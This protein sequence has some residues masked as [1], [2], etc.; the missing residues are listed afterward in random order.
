MKDESV[1][2]KNQIHINEFVRK[3][4]ENISEPNSIKESEEFI[5]LNSSILDF[6]NKYLPLNSGLIDILKKIQNISLSI[7]SV[8]NLIN[9]YTQFLNNIHTDIEKTFWGNINKQVKSNSLPNYLSMGDVNKEKESLGD[10]SEEINMDDNKLLEKYMD[11][12]NRNMQDMEKRLAEDRRD[13]E[14]RTEEQRRLSE[15]RMEKN[16]SE[17]MDAIKYQNEKIDKLEDKIDNNA[18]ELRNI[19]VTTIWSMI[20]IVAAIA[21]LVLTVILTIK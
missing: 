3:A 2:T 11:S 17:A 1:E 12:V 7:S 19:S 20:G 13:S 10:K 16:F 8:N 6:R 14:K 9:P 15:E 18:K 5:D 21:A 4:L